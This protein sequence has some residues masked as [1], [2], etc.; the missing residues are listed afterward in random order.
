MSFHLWRP[1]LVTFPE[2]V[3]WWIFYINLHSPK[4]QCISEMLVTAS[5]KSY[6]LA[7]LIQQNFIYNSQIVHCKCSLLLDSSGF[8]PMIGAVQDEQKGLQAY[9]VGGWG[10]IRGSQE[11]GF[12][13]TRPLLLVELCHMIMPDSKG[14]WKCNLAQ[15]PRRRSGRF[16]KQLVSFCYSKS[17]IF[18]A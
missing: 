9:S 1:E 11:G 15:W 7:G 18:K 5:E 8:S 12:L 2:S 13:W 14:D 17:I 6:I 3:L 4:K 10:K 16:D